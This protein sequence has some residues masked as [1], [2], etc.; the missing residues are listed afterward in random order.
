MGKVLVLG[1][2]PA[3]LL[4]THAAVQGGHEVRVLSKKTPSYIAGAQFLHTPIPE[5]T[6]DNPDGQLEFIKWGTSLGYAKKIYGDANARTSWNTYPA[7]FRSVWNLRERYHQ[8]WKFYAD[9]ITD[10]LWLPQLA[11]VASQEFDVILSTI[12][13]PHVIPEAVLTTETVRIV[14][15]EERAQPMT[16]VYNGDPEDEWYRSSDIFGHA[17]TEYPDGPSF[18]GSASINK[19]LSAD[20]AAI[21]VPNLFLLGRYGK[22]QK[23]VLVDDAY[24]E[25]VTIVGNFD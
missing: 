18:I 21:P 3:G 14:A 16:I 8:L 5:L 20:Y 12:P 2:G 10:S 13:I 19:P 9:L 24:R 17:S 23:G 22:W 11:Q 25:A 4:A 1:C 15:G 6:R 7:G